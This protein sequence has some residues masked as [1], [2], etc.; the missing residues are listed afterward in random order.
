M[1]KIAQNLTF[2]FKKIDKN[3]PFF[4]KIAI[5][6]FFEKSV[7]FWA[8]FGQSNGNFP[9]G[10]FR[11]SAISRWTLNQPDWPEMR[12]IYDQMSVN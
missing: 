8:I 9:E 4:N 5:V 7:M 10:Q 3:C 1:S 11:T 2:F 6:N 12:V